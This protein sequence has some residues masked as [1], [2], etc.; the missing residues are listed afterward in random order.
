MVKRED[1]Q[2]TEDRGQRTE[3]RG[4]RKEEGRRMED[5]GWRKEE[6]EGGRRK[7]EGG[8][9]NAFKQKITSL[10]PLVWICLDP[11]TTTCHQGC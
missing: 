7:E 9:R 5:G 4:Q 8:R 2:R 6:G 1:L 10:D 11:S 3:D